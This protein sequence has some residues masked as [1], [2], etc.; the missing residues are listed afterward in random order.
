VGN[1]F[2]KH[3]TSRYAAAKALAVSVQS[4]GFFLRGDDYRLGEDK[5]MKLIE[6][7]TETS[8]K[9]WTMAKLERARVEIAAVHPIRENLL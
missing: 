4:L 8:G 2:A 7:L 6:H 9:R 1:F 5:R 3:K